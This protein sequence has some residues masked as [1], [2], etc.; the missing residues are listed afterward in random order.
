LA[1][2]VL[3]FAPYN[4]EDGVW[5]LVHDQLR[6][7]VTSK[8]KA[9]LMMSPSMP[10]CA[11]FSPRDWQAVCTACQE[12]DAWLLYDSAMERILFEGL[13]QIHPASFPGMAER[14]ISVGAVSKE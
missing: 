6:Q 12:A 10:R 3:A 11:V 4:I 13:E 8:T 14:T 9:F 7:A 2:G 5:R 1:G